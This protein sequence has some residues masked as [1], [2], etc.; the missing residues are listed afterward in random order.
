MQSKKPRHLGVIISLALSALVIGFAAWLFLNR[1]Y[2]ID[3]ITVW[4]Y[5]PPA[6]IQSINE[7]VDFTG[8][9]TFAFYATQPV[10]ADAEAFNQG[11]PR[12]EVGSPIL[13]C[14]SAGRIYVYNVDNEQLA[15][16]EEVTAAHEMLHAAWERLSSSERQQVTTLLDAAYSRLSS[17]SE[18]KLRMDYYARTEPGQM[19]NE[20]HSILGTEMRDVGDDLEAYYAR[21]FTDRRKVLDL[22][23]A[24]NAVF[25][26]LKNESADLY[27]E[28]TTLATT[29]TTRSKSYET[30]VAQLS[31]DIQ[32]FNQ[33]AAS[34]GFS[35]TS[36]FNR[37]RAAIVKRWQA[38]EAE[39]LAINRDVNAY[40]VK[41]EQYQQL[42]SQLD[43]LHKSVDSFRSLEQPPSLD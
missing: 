25:T 3:Q 36:Q 40:N 31:A 1:Q 38:V 33:R 27:T 8:H 26:N 43:T 6:S 22:H 30:T 12:Q 23:G 17:D 18:L 32:S 9:G 42:A 35:S 10:L 29:L 14:Y 4:S 20:L 15:G 7:R 5:T 13:G 19:Y 28:L 24:Y 16:M 21:Y 39:R 2:V 11:C 37:E 41:Y 34:G